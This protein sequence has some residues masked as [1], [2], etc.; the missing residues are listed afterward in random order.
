MSDTESSLDENNY[1]RLPNNYHR[2]SP[3]CILHI[4]CYAMACC[5][6]SVVNKWWNKTIRYWFIETQKHYN[7]ETKT[8]YIMYNVISK[9]CSNSVQNTVQIQ[10]L[11]Q[12]FV[13]IQ[14]MIIIILQHA[15]TYIMSEKSWLIWS[16]LAVHAIEVL[17][18]IRRGKFTCIHG[19]KKVKERMEGVEM[20]ACD[21]GVLLH[22]HHQFPFAIYI[23]NEKMQIKVY[24]LI[25]KIIIV[26]EQ[27]ICWKLVPTCWYL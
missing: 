2:V 22:N 3:C 1:V 20:S 17:I 18:K 26:R 25:F 7:N 13:Q 14:C 5:I 23:L 9:L 10:R 24:F 15:H 4:F 27:E 12:N 19:D 11:F 21:P 6:L 8:N 16:W